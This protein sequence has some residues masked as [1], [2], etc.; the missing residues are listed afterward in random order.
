MSLILTSF[1]RLTRVL[2]VTLWFCV[3]DV[4]TGKTQNWHGTKLKILKLTLPAI[5]INDD[6]GLFPSFII[7]K[8]CLIVLGI[9]C[10]IITFAYLQGNPAVLSNIKQLRDFYVIF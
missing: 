10:K 8:T 5:A 7:Q 2:I 1:N 6:R 3:F 4:S 9:S